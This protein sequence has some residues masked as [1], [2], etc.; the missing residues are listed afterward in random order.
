MP[1]RVSTTIY[2]TFYIFPPFFAML[3]SYTQTYT[4]ISIRTRSRTCSTSLSFPFQTWCVQLSLS[5]QFSDCV[6]AWCALLYIFLLSPPSAATTLRT[7]TVYLLYS[8]AVCVY[9]H[10]HTHT[11]AAY[12]E[13]T[14]YIVHEPFLEISIKRKADTRA[15]IHRISILIL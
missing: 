10:T 4:H 12:T 13:R 11:P 7:C 14:T 9:T 3:D 15:H 1:L 6:Y 8:N 5:I 2:S